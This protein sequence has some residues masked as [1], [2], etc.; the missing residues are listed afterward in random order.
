MLLGWGFRSGLQIVSGDPKE[1]R[2]PLPARVILSLSLLLSAMLSALTL[3]H[4]AGY[5]ILAGMI[6]SFFG[7]MFNAAV[8]PLS[9][10]RLG[11]MVAFAMAHPFYI[12]SFYFLLKPTA[13]MTASFFWTALAAFWLLTAIGWYLFARN[14]EILPVIN[15][16]TLIYA[17]IIGT[18]A[19]FALTLSLKMGGW[20][21]T[22]FLGALLFCISDAI[23]GITD[24]G[25]TALK[26]PHLWIWLTYI[27]GQMGIIYGIWLG[28][29]M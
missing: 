13:I 14:S 6:F 1:I 5:L 26:R 28:L 21:W 25:G 22:V 23:I 9:A 17:L 24:F 16:G 15:A 4:P 20:W 8:I 19:V 3:R 11:G 18:M 12:A 10:P 27:P 29:V 7:D 2:L